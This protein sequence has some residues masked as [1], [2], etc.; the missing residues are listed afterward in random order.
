MQLQTLKVHR[1]YAVEGAVQ[2][3]MRPQGKVHIMYFLVYTLPHKP[4]N[5][6]AS[7]CAVA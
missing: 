6:A 3:F 4:L 7:N 2:R 1:S 5:V